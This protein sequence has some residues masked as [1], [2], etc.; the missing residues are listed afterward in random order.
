LSG[1]ELQAKLNAEHCKDSN[2][3]ITAHGERKNADAGLRAGAV[4]FMAAVSTEVLLESVPSSLG[5]LSSIKSS[6]YVD[7]TSP[8][9]SQWQQLSK[10]TAVVSRIPASADSSKS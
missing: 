9:G 7:S 5:E 2:H 8:G 10:D 4:E 6:L 1:L 3:L